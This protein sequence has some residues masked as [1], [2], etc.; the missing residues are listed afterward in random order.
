MSQLF[1]L[2]LWLPKQFQNGGLQRRF[3]GMNF[4]RIAGTS[5][6][7]LVI[8]EYMKSKLFGVIFSFKVLVSD[9]Q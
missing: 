1:C 7:L 4:L 2:G 5:E 3:F 8:G 6:C 9:N